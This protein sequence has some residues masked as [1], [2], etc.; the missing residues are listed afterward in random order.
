V[1]YNFDFD[2]DRGKK[3]K[4][5][6]KFSVSMPW[7]FPEEMAKAKMHDSSNGQVLSLLKKWQ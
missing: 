5:E 2:I 1:I 6:N 4:K 7:H 3:E